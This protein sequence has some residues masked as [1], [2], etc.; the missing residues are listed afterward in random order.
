M[1][2]IEKNEKLSR[3]FKPVI[4]EYVINKAYLD[5][6]LSKKEGR[7]SFLENDYIEFKLQCNKESAEE[8]LIQRGVKTTIQLLYD[9]GLFDGFPNADEVLKDFLFVRRRRGDLVERK[10]SYSTILF[11]NT[12]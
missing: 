4:D 2:I 1:I 3:S 11:M 7:L 5:E 9:T 6:K 8:F 12:I 10:G